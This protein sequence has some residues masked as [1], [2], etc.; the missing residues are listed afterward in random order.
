MN[1]RDELDR[2]ERYP[3]QT[4]PALRSVF[5]ERA[6]ELD[7]SSIGRLRA[8]DYRPRLGAAR[9]LR[10]PLVSLGLLRPTE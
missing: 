7:P 1:H 6:G 10:G 2:Q 9:R 3:G 5:L 8:I 4:E